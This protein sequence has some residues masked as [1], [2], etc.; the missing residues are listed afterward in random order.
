MPRP[1][2]DDLKDHDTDGEPRR[3]TGGT[4]YPGKLLCAIVLPE[5]EL[6]EK[7]IGSDND[8]D[9]DAG[10]RLRIGE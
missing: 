8:T 5:G 3:N 1:S 6:Y 7:N 9:N 2:A 10:G 4:C